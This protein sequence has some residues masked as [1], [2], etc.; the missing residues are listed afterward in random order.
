MLYRYGE[1]HHNAKISAEQVRDV[2]T[3][4]ADGAPL[5]ELVE[6]TGISRKTILGWND[7]NNRA[8]ETEDIRMRIEELRASTTSGRRP[9]R[10][11]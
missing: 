3:R 10:K 8:G 4:Y 2:L 1:N 11:S 6:Q 9:R 5:P 7:G